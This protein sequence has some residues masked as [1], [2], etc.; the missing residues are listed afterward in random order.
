MGIQSLYNTLA[1]E[2]EAYDAILARGIT[3]FSEVL[4]DPQILEMERQYRVKQN[5]LS[6]IRLEND[7]NNDILSSPLGRMGINSDSEQEEQEEQEMQYDVRS[8]A[9][10][11]SNDNMNQDFIRF[12]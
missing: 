7:D 10:I 12:H 11:D 5:P 1:Q 4:I 3:S 6:Q 2:Q 8:V 9:T